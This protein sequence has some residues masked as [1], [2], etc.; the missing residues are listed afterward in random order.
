M[1]QQQTTHQALAAASATVQ[2]HAAIVVISPPQLTN[3]ATLLQKL[4]AT[5]PSAA[6]TQGGL[7]QQQATPTTG[8]TRYTADAS[9]AAWSTT[10]PLDS[11]STTTATP[12]C[13]TTLTNARVDSAIAGLGECRTTPVSQLQQQQV[14]C[15]MQQMVQ[16]NQ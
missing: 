16:Q 11:P 1:Q 3:M 6:Q 5:S 4:N 9:T 13:T 8:V 14:Q 7:V 2:Y 15:L 12:T 10:S